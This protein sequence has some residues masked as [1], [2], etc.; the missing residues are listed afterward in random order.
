MK[1]CNESLDTDDSDGHAARRLPKKCLFILCFFLTAI[2]LFISSQMTGIDITDITSAARDEMLQLA[3]NITKSCSFSNIKSEKGRGECQEICKYHSCCVWNDDVKTSHGCRNDPDMMC[4]VYVGCKSLFNSDDDDKQYNLEDINVGIPADMIASA[5]D[6]T[7]TVVE[8]S[9]TQNDYNQSNSELGLISHVISTVCENGNLHTHQ[10]LHECGALCSSSICCFNHTNIYALNPHVDTILKLEG[11]ALNLT[12]M[13]KCM[14]DE[15]NHF[16]Q[17]HSGCKKLLLIGSSNTGSAVG[18]NEATGGNQE[19]VVMRA[20]MPFGIVI[21]IVTYLLMQKRLPSPDT[22]EASEQD[23]LVE[24]SGSDRE[25]N[26]IWDQEM[27]CLHLSNH[28][29]MI[30]LVISHENMIT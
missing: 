21:C 18:D 20:L 24:A 23:N 1:S 27:G 6:Q 2:L 25:M 28:M 5:S 3:E 30:T 19:N 7:S 17:A 22:Y 13:G 10:G 9:S 12:S 29:R 15:S 4:P 16:C 26:E 14:N 11:V 8:N